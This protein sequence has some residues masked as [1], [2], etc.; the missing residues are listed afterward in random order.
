MP[1]NTTCRTLNTVVREKAG[2]FGTALVFGSAPVVAFSLPNHQG[3]EAWV[4]G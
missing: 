1:T 4:G 3:A 2:K